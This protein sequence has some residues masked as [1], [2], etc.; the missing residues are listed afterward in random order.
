MRKITLFVAAMCC[1]TMMYA[2]PAPINVHWEGTTIK[3]ECPELTNDSVYR[4]ASVNLYTSTGVS[5]T[6]TSGLFSNNEYDLSSLMYHGRTYYAEVALYASSGPDDRNSVWSEHTTSPDYT[7]PGAKDTLEFSPVALDESGDVTWPD[8]YQKVRATLQKKNGLV[9][10]DIDST[11]SKGWNHGWSFGN[12]SEAG[13]Y[14]AIVDLIQDEDVV[15]RGITNE[16]VIDEIFTVTF[17]AQSL[18][19]NP[20]SARVAKNSLVTKP[21]IDEA[22]KSQIG[23]FFYWSS[24]AAGENIWDFDTAHVTADTTIYAQWIELPALNPVWDED[25]CRWTLA[26]KYYVLITNCVLHILTGENGDVLGAAGSPRN[27]WVSSDCLLPG[28]DYKFAVKLYDAYNNII[29]DTSAIRTITGEPTTLTLENMTVADASEAFI[30]WSGS[31]VIYN[32]SLSLEGTIYQWND[33]TNEWVVLQTI[34]ERS[35][36]SYRTNARF[37]VALDA[38]EYYRICCQLNQGEYVI[39][40]GEMYYGTNPATGIDNVQSDNVQCTKVIRDGQLY[41]MYKGQ[42]YNVQGQE[43]K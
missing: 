6:G 4:G 9:W 26:E 30:T 1:T 2:V 36:R 5:L 27:N 33:G 34:N 42:M 12:F 16:V 7:V 21:E 19:D 18:F 23:H 3:W 37:Y 32:V 41:L 25:T 24:D 8:D 22:Y 43:V 20:T 15:R 13:T 28:R 11:C 17:N 31:D 40:I 10:D 39:Y 35:A 14:R 38:D 29:T